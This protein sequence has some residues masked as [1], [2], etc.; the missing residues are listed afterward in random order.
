MFLIMNDDC[1][2]CLPRWSRHANQAQMLPSVDESRLAGYFVLAM[3][4]PLCRVPQAGV[5]VSF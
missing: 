1:L 4:I 2:P 5:V 3:A